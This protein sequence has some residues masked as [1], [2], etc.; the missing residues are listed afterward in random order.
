MQQ[1]KNLGKGSFKPCKPIPNQDNLS[2]F[3]EEDSARPQSKRL[4]SPKYAPTTTT[5]TDHYNSPKNS[6]SQLG[7]NPSRHWKS[8][9]APELAKLSPRDGGN[10]NLE[11]ELEAAPELSSGSI[12]R[13]KGYSSAH[14]LRQFDHSNLSSQLQEDRADFPNVQPHQ[15]IRKEEYS[16][17]KE[18]IMNR[19]KL[20]QERAS[21]EEDRPQSPSQQQS[22][23]QTNQ[24][25]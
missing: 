14:N 12:N 11:P 24:L 5:T 9:L 10:I 19:I 15:T 17:R 16:R 13:L 25:R 23:G 1:Y 6:S 21:L 8:Y 7:G 4:Y 2:S 20:L 3:E 18:E 22:L